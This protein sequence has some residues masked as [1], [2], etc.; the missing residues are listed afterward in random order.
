MVVAADAAVPRRPPQ[1]CPTPPLQQPATMSAGRPAGS[2]WACA[3]A[4]I[5]LK[6]GRRVGGR[7]RL[8]LL[9]A[10]YQDGRRPRSAEWAAPRWLRPRRPHHHGCRLLYGTQDGR[11]QEKHSK[12][13]AATGGCDMAAC[14]AWGRG[15]VGWC[16]WRGEVSRVLL[17]FLAVYRDFELSPEAAILHT[18]GKSLISKT[19]LCPR[20]QVPLLR[21]LETVHLMFCQG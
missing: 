13:V 18:V 1:R 8:T 20:R 17:S 5:L 7:H 2:L 6:G 9:K 3:R 19:P 15:G 12:M 11:C 4:A 14:P 10:L 16:I 21:G